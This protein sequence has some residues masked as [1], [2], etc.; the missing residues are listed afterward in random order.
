MTA[1]L[2]VALLYAASL[3]IYG[4]ERQRLAWL[5][6]R[7]RVIG[8]RLAAAL[9]SGVALALWRALEDGRVGRTD[10]PARRR[11]KTSGLGVEAWRIDTSAWRSKR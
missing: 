7:P 6:S 5:R 10:R 3:L 8:A 4:S 9:F 1:W 2:C 11:Q